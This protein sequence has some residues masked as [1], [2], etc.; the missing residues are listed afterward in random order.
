MKV[1]SLFFVLVISGLA[2]GKT[3]HVPVD[4]PTIQFAIDMSVTGDL[5]IVSLGTYSEAINFGGKIITVQSINPNDPSVTEQTIIDA[6]NAG[7]GI[8]SP[9]VVAFASGGDNAVL[10]GFTITGGTVGI[11]GHRSRATVRDCVIR[12]NAQYGIKEFDG[13]ITRCIIRNNG[14]TYGYGDA[15]IYDCDGTISQC[16]VEHNGGYGGV[17]NC[18]GSTIDTRIFHNNVGIREGTGKIIRCTVSLN[19]YGIYGGSNLVVQQSLISGNEN[20]GIYGGNGK[21]ENS[22]ISGNKADGVASYGGTILDCTIT[23]NL[24]YGLNG[25]NGLIKHLI[26][27]DNPQGALTASSLPIQSGTINPFFASPGYRD[28][29][30]QMWVD[31]D[32]HLRAGSPYIDAGLIGFND[33]TV[34]F[35]GNPRVVN[36]RV[37]IGAYEFQS[38][39]HGH[40]FDDDGIANDCDPDMDN[41]GVPNIIDVCPFTYPNLIVNDEGRPYADMNNDCKVD[42][43]DFAFFQNQISGN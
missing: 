21:I 38:N 34:D 35:D 39:C 7:L 9:Y 20:F 29:A 43:S 17:W 14:R 40:D 30:T 13:S 28:P 15:G 11:D 19:D 22:I 12:N 42:L 16:L 4:S 24:R 3:I 2:L 8:G 27:W 10:A 36:G 25:C 37:D 18:D 6:T 33:S 26:I 31:G 23:Q 5:I 41:D 1:C 32:Y